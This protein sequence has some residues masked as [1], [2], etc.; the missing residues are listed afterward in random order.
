M[1]FYGVSMSVEGK[2]P[3]FMSSPD[4][5][6]NQDKFFEKHQATPRIPADYYLGWKMAQLQLSLGRK[7]LIYLDT[8]HWVNLRHVEMGYRLQKP[9][10]QTM[11]QLL[12]RLHQT[13]RICCPISFLLFLELMKQ[14]DVNTRMKTANLMDQFSGGLCF[15]FPLEMTESELRHFI[16]R[17]IPS[18]EQGPKA[19]VFTKAG[20]IGGHLLPTV[21]L[22]DKETNNLI[23]KVWI[24]NMWDVGLSDL[25]EDLDAFGFTDNYWKRY[26]AQANQEAGIYRTESHSYEDALMLQKAIFVRIM[27]DEDLERVSRDIFEKYPEC[28][29]PKN[30]RPVGETEY[31]PHHFP[32]LQI[33]AGIHAANLLSTMKFEANDML[34]F[35]HASMAIPYCDAICCDNPMATRLRDKP[36]EFGNIYGAKIFGK[37]EEI[38]DYLEKLEKL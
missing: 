27:I 16:I 19:W 6:K 2:K 30:L 28:A 7:K 1:L 25:I 10:Y 31:S 35:R 36:C 29:D 24:D 11:L 21:E 17:R 26:A 8:N 12:T 9:A 18:V 14:S 5:E 15:Q 37:A 3:K 23:Q 13:G 33:L 4:F 38:N 32:S 20:F 34:D 22:F